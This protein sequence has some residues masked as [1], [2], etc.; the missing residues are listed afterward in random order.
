[1]CERVEAA[2]PLACCVSVSESERASERSRQ[3][4]KT[5]S[6]TLHCEFFSFSNRHVVYSSWSTTISSLPAHLGS[7]RFSFS[8]CLSKMNMSLNFCNHRTAVPQ[9]L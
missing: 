1:M 4:K 6:Q 5:P 2:L 8:L 7:L 3:V 9:T